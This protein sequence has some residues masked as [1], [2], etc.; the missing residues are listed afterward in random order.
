MRIH[1]RKSGCIATLTLLLSVLFCVCSA[2]SIAQAAAQPSTQPIA[3]KS[4][5]K[6]ATKEQSTADAHK[7]P[8]ER[9]E[10]V[11]R[12]VAIVNNDIVLESDIEE[13][14]RFAKLYPYRTTS[15]DT[16]REQALTRLIDRDLIL[17]QMRNGQT[18]VTP[19]QVDKQEVELR[20]DLPA[21]A[22]ADCTSAAG[23]KKFLTG[24]GFTEEELRERLR[25]RAQVLR[26]IEQ[27]FRSGIH[28]TDAQIEDFYRN[29]MLPQYQ[30]EH[31]TAPPLAVLSSRIQEVLLQQQVS[32]LLDQWLKSLRDNGSVRILKEGEEAP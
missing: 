32:A 17:Q 2:R 30:K 4:Q 6:P 5:G 8:A 24:A 10:I 7:L 1:L 26:F 31:A 21:C 15:G 14:E 19:E 25:L 13:E 18:A 11:D 22:R 16:P 28:I 9:G 23:W 29:T 27:R 3:P 20:K 12:M